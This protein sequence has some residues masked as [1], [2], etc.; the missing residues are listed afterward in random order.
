MIRADGSSSGE[1]RSLLRHESGVFE[2]VFAPDARGLIYRTGNAS[3]GLAD[4]GFVDLETDTASV[5]LL[6]SPFNERAVDLSADGRW[7]AYVSD[8]SGWDEVYVRPFPDVDAYQVPVSSGGGVEP[9]WA[10]N[11]RELFYRTGQ[12]GAASGSLRGDH[13]MVATYVTEPDFRIE[14]RDTLFDA[15]QYALS[16]GVGATTWHAY[17]VDHVDQRFVMIRNVPISGDR[18]DP[19]IVFVRNFVE[20]LRERVPS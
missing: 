1:S 3:N 11:G 13:M 6:A 8:F 15:T 16:P 7:L 14:S 12:T 17:D 18:P 19:W 20:E 2:V 4:L 9:V 10:H 5:D